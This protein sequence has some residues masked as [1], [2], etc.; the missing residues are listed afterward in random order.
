[1]TDPLNE[2]SP[3]SRLVNQRRHS[4]RYRATLLF[5]GA[6][7]VLGLF[8]YAMSAPVLT[9]VGGQLIHVDP[10]EPA[11]A[12]VVLAPWLDRVVEAAELY[13]AG[14]A[15][16]IVLTREQRQPAEQLLIDRGIV[17]SGEERRRRALIALG[18]PGDSVLI[19]DGF[20]SSTA[21]EARA[22][23]RWSAP[24][25]V[26]RIIV[27]TSPY[28]TARARATFLRSLER[29]GTDVLLH[30]SSLGTPFASDTW[31]KSRATLR[32]GLMEWQKL[33]YYRL[34]ELPRMSGNGDTGE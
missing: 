15:P 31:W 1:M 2:M 32:D 20:V 5:A 14:F 26:R 24:R 23:A 18:I 30:A 9:V 11:D 10:L 22:F 4:T 13:R 7:A 25:S 6:I 27:V 8:F 33:V 19:I 28:H 16:L 12:I 3:L 34:I 21:D 29:Q 17:E